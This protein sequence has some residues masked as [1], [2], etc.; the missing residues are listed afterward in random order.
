MGPWAR[1][2]GAGSGVIPHHQYQH[3][4]AV[5]VDWPFCNGART[6]LTDS[7]ASFYD[8][9]W[10]QADEAHPAGVIAGA[11]ESGSLDLW[12]AAKLIAGD[13]DALLSRT[14]KHSGHI[15]SLQFN[16]Q[17]PHVLVT[18]GYRGELYVYDI[19]DPESA[20]R[21]GTAAARTDNLECVAW[22]CGR[23]VSHIL[24]TGGDGGFVMVWDLKTKKAS[25][26][27]NVRKPVS[28]LAWDPNNATKL[29]VTTSDDNNP[30]ISLWDLRNSNAPERVMQG[31]EQGVL[32]LSWCAK[33]SDLLLSCG[34]D[35]KTIVWNPQSGEKYGEL[36]EA[37]NW[38]FSTRF[39]PH[40]PSIVATASFDGKIVVQTLQNTNPQ[41]SQ[42]AAA[43]NVNGDDFFSAAPV[44]YTH[45]TLPT[46][47]SV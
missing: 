8:I 24:A 36:P 42:A 14:T 23:N 4:L 28:A 34:K 22:N 38:T 35:N 29:L 16:P 41:S 25:W 7:F 19:N 39:N 21:L 47:C 5:G 20:F 40:N 10:G 37:T 12:D 31:H 43:S 3:R 9:A 6:P 26:T 33:D 30:A 17:R 1:Q 45:L 27:L 18:A 46:I 2:P 44:S 15:K 11:L 32:S 13:S